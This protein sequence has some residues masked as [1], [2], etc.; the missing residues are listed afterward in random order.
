MCLLHSS[1]FYSLELSDE[2]S[3]CQSGC[4]SVCQSGCQPVCQCLLVRLICPCALTLPLP[5]PFPFG[6]LFSRRTEQEDGEEPSAAV[7]L[8]LD[9]L[10]AVVKE[11]RRP[12]AILHGQGVGRGCDLVRC[13]EEKKTQGD[14]FRRG[15]CAGKKRVSYEN[16]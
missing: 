5:F 8:A 7:A 15:P 11:D 2:K 1:R 4:Q 6:F 13:T 12:A 9:V 3:V 10:G 16:K 14:L